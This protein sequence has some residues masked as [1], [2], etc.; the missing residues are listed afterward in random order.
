MDSGAG[1]S[2]T[3][4]KPPATGE[5]GAS[6][7]TR[8]LDIHLGKVTLY[9][10]SYTR[11]QTRKNFTRKPPKSK[12]KNLHQKFSLAFF[13]LFPADFQC[14]LFEKSEQRKNIDAYK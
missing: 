2:S 11:I 8:T 3:K 13:S 12:Q 4:R 10:L 6:E 5:N 1:L 9:Q 7:E 14:G